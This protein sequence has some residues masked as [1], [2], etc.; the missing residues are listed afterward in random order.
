MIIQANNPESKS[1]DLRQ[2][3]LAMLHKL[4]WN[5]QPSY[6]I[7]THPKNSVAKYLLS[8]TQLIICS[9]GNLRYQIS[10]EKN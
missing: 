2:D 1:Q 5:F 3:V 10:R 4:N 6:V 8:E 7:G 9:L